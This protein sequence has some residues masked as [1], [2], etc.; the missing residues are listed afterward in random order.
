MIK[1]HESHVIISMLAFIFM[2]IIVKFRLAKYHVAEDSE[3]SG[4]FAFWWS[5]SDIFFFS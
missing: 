4:G 5:M 1:D 3:R 2:L